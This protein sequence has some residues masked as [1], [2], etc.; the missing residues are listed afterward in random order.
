MQV[1]DEVKVA[2]GFPVE[3]D[4]R[5]TDQLSCTVKGHI[6]AAVGLLDDPPA[7]R[8]QVSEAA[9]EAMSRQVELKLGDF[10]IEVEVVAV[11]P[12]PVVTRFELLPAPGLKVSKVSNLAKDL[13]RSLST[14]SVRIVE[15]IPGKSV[16][17]LEIPNEERDLVVLGELLKSEEY[18][19]EASPLTL[20]LGEAQRR[21][22]RGKEVAL[23]GVGSGL[24]CIIVGVQW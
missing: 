3:F 22:T 21:I 7:T 15:V 11:H 19:R 10:G 18:D 16:I 8:G 6:A 23:F 4:D 2:V 9:L 13:A 20:A 14:I 17:G 12:G 1:T 5:I 24:Q